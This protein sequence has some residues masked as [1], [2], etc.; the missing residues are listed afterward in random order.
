MNGS[1]RVDDATRRTFTFFMIGVVIT[2][3]VV[4]LVVGFVKLIHTGR[5]LAAKEKATVYI[6]AQIETEYLK[7]ISALDR[8]AYG[9]PE[10]SADAVRERFEILWSRLPVVL[11]GED[12]ALA[13]TVEGVVP[14]AESLARTLAEIEPI[15]IDLQPGDTA[16]YR[17]IRTVLDPF[18][19]A[20]H[21]AVVATHL[22]D[23]WRSQA[24]ASGMDSL[25]LGIA[26][27]FIGMLVGGAL[28]VLFLVREVRRANK[29]LRKATEAE[30]RTLRAEA[31]L[32]DAIEAIPQGIALFD[33]DDRLI[34]C[35]QR[36]QSLVADAPASVAP[37][38]PFADLC[39][40]MID[41]GR[42][43]IAPNCAEEWLEGRLVRHRSGCNREEIRLTDGRWLSVFDRKSC[44]GDII[45]VFTDIT[46]V[47]MREAIL[48][49]AR[50]QAELA[51]RAKSEFLA[52]MSH[53][54]RTPLNAIIGFSEMIRDGAF[55]PIG[56][57]KYIEYAGDI[58]ASGR[59][60][61]ELIND[62]LD[63]SKIEA[64]EIRLNEE[65]VDIARIAH[66]CVR[67]VARRAQDNGLTI[68]LDLPDELPLL[69][70][71]ERQVKQILINLLSNAVKFTEPG[72]RISL[73]IRLRDDR[74]LEA[75]ITDTGIGIARHDLDLVMK[76][77][78]QVDSKL[79]R[80]YEGTG[81]GL[82]LCKSLVELHGGRLV[83][84]SELGA[85]T[86][87][88]VVFPPNRVRAKLPKL[89]AFTPRKRAVCGATCAP[90]NP[91]CCMPGER[92]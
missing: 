68:D 54:L 66:A 1:R 77:F 53:E 84:E 36:Y 82:P 76:P 58:H 56:S 88:R 41:E 86:T 92:S 25:I 81:L 57:P 35:N 67:L 83:L 39:R 46:D 8:L 30:A 5:Q 78:T 15:V 73:R 21:R 27:A 85:G 10:I 60:L 34:L 29:L 6:V 64:G 20:I 62:I 70:A 37:G 90:A 22:K 51:N 71:D 17:R 28:L 31:R 45:S 26:F 49:E 75:T 16:G 23:R 32:V 2:V 4:S 44:D 38:V 79:A 18:A 7:F 74:R 72:G 33:A 59:H 63:I 50:Q 52:N 89:V 55:G 9:D 47:K 43:E 80:R 12:G 42:I 91:S 11:K 48:N 69:L 40:A 61:L 14:L 87:V 13:R 19:S 3:F 24:R 65:E